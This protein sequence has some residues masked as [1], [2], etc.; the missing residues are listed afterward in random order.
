MA[1]GSYPEEPPMARSLKEIE[2]EL[3]S[4]TRKSTRIMMRSG[5][6]SLLDETMKL[7]RVR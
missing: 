5:E 4:L 1:K 7:N 6:Q 2:K 3:L